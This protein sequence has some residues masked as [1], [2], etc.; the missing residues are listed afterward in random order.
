M[1]FR[2]VPPSVAQT[3]SAARRVDPGHGLFV[4]YRPGEAGA[5][6]ELHPFKRWLILRTGDQTCISEAIACS[7][8]ARTAWL[9]AGAVT[10]VPEHLTPR[11]GRVF[12]ALVEALRSG[13][14]SEET[15]S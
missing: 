14:C 1:S 8:L 3:L 9:G 2:K 13:A 10:A 15:A 5:A 4:T 11:F 7:L 6:W 12:D